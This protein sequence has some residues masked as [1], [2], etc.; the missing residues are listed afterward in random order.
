MVSC[1]S[2]H[3]SHYLKIKSLVIK[4]ERFHR[5]TVGSLEELG[6][7]CGGGSPFPLAAS[8]DPYRR[9]PTVWHCPHLSL[10]G[11]TQSLHIITVSGLPLK[12]GVCH[13]FFS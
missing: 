13:L 6:R 3:I 5:K 8:S 10:L 12:M 2:M 11:H 1:N 7:S 4:T 9:T